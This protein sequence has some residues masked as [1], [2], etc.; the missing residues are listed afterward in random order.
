MRSLALGFLALLHVSLAE[1][2]RKAGRVRAQLARDART[3]R[4]TPRNA[5]GNSRGC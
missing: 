3:V 5:V 4:A 1:A 2:G